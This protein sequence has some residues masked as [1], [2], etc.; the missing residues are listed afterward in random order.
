MPKEKSSRASKRSAPYP[1]FR[2]GERHYKK[3]RTKVLSYTLRT[4]YPIS[5]RS[6]NG[7]TTLV[8]QIKLG[9]REAAR[10]LNMPFL[11][12]CRPSCD[13]PNYSEADDA[14]AANKV[15]RH[16]FNKDIVNYLLIDPATGLNMAFENAELYLDGKDVTEHLQLGSMQ[17]HYQAMDRKTAPTSTLRKMGIDYMVRTSDDRN[18]DEPVSKAFTAMRA[19]TEFSKYNED[20]NLAIPLGFDGVPLLGRP[21]CLTLSHLNRQESGGE[22]IDENMINAVPPETEIAIHLHLR[23][24]TGISMDYHTV[25]DEEYFTSTPVTEANDPRPANA[26]LDIKSIVFRYMSYTVPEGHNLDRA[27]THPAPMHIDVPHVFTNLLDSGTQHT[28]TEVRVPAGAKIA[29]LA[30]A[31]GHQLWP[32]GGHRKNLSARYTYPDNLS[33]IEVKLRDHGFLIER[34]FGP[35]TGTNSDN[36]AVHAYLDNLRDLGLMDI[37]REQF[38]P[39]NNKDKSYNH[40]LFLDLRPFHLKDPTV[41]TVSGTWTDPL[42][43][44][45]YYLVTIFVTEGELRRH[46]PGRWELKRSIGT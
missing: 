14:A 28:E 31:Y 11:V 13:N 32:H 39:T 15:K 18:L 23:S 4:V 16:Q 46:G 44:T 2:F 21:L 35:F 36:P 40:V 42:S 3:M 45:N 9:K 37:P 7:E 6:Y 22:E 30:F 10:F 1:G 17:P 5:G 25:T 34:G 38:L 29:F 19:Q 12:L 20:R 8:F 27:M 26:S 41:L 43:P 24:D 33:D